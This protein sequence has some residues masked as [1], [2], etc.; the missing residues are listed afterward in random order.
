[1]PNN[2]LPRIKI[3]H[4]RD[5]KLN[6]ELNNPILLGGEIGIISD[7]NEIKIGDG[8]TPFNDLKSTSISGNSGTASK[9]EN[10]RKIVLSG[11][12][13]G[14]STF[15]GSKDITIVTSGKNLGSSQLTEESSVQDILS[16]LTE[17]SGGTKI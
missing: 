13:T 8:V 17:V 7:T 2:L 6:W 14:E 12:V 11:F 16:W 5:T 10:E 4:R 9:L 3:Q 1:M 15:D